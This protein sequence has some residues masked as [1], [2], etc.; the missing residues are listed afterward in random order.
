MTPR[1]R[2]VPDEASA[3]ALLLALARRAS[4]GNAVVG[5]VGLRLGEG[6][7]V[8]EGGA[9]PWIIARP[10][11]SRGWS[12]PDGEAGAPELELLFDLYMP[13]CVGAGAATLTIAHLGQSLD[14]RIATVSGKSQFITGQ[15]NLLHAHRLRALCDVVLV[16]RRTVHE[17]D[18]QLTTRLCAGPSPVRVIVD[19]GRR[20]RT[21]RRVFQN[22]QSAT[23][24]F[25]SAAASK[26]ETHHGHAE[27]VAI[28]PVEAR[29]PVTSILGE[30][31]RRGLNR[32]FIEGGGVTVS[33]FV[34]ARAL[35]R[36]QVTV[37][38]VIF[39]SG[40]PMLVL[41]EIDDL[42][43]ALTL[44]CRRFQLGP[45]ILFDCTLSP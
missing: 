23:L 43:Q 20:L 3:W 4:A 10:E 2:N 24:L 5:D 33:R 16:G 38:P 6:G 27:V 30:L 18:P 13:L 26:A 45:D 9:D 7:A 37:A 15:E 32:V 14:G 31:R 1:K 42:S 22:G 44:A 21:D 11:T 8:E 35:T 19:P 29:L 36:L 40:R 25:C 34:E 39:G 17:D 28:Q 41:P 12:W